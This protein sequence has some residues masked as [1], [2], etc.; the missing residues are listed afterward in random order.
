MRLHISVMSDAQF[1]ID[2]LSLI[3][4]KDSR[5]Q[6]ILKVCHLLI[7][8][9]LYN[10]KIPDLNGLK[11]LLFQYKY[12]HCNYMNVFSKV[13]SGLKHNKLPFFYTSHFQVIL[14]Y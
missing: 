3:S 7:P 6:Q 14:V 13:K 9:D 1:A 12:K 11:S 5:T 2:K 10:T 8:N 4:V